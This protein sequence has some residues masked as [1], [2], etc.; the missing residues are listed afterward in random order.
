[1]NTNPKFTIIVV[2]DAKVGKSTFI[3]RHNTGEFLKDHV[4]TDAI[5]ST[6][7][8]FTTTSGPIDIIVREV[9]IGIYNMPRCDGCIVMF[10]TCNKNSFLNVDYWINS[11]LNNNNIPIVICG[12]K[13]DI[14]DSKVFYRDVSRKFQLNT[15]NKVHTYYGIS[16]RS[17]YKYDKPFL[18]LIRSLVGDNNLAFS[19]SMMI[20][21][22]PGYTDALGAT[23]PVEISVLSSHIIS[24]N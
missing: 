3:H 13:V 20:Q 1:M 7:L 10:D 5:V 18:S 23:Y 17:G 12:N 4:A 21:D 15:P 22:M 2:G 19:D 16:T 6:R 11:V 14:K 9:P 8:T 24:S